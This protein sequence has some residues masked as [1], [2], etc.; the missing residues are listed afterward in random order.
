MV[1]AAHS[2]F[3]PYSPEVVRPWL[4]HAWTG[5]SSDLFPV[6]FLPTRR[7]NPDGSNNLVQGVT[8]LGHGALPFVFE[9]ADPRAWTVRTPFD[10]R[11]GFTLA[12][13]EGGCRITHTIELEPPFYMTALWYAFIARGHDWAIL[14]IF[15]RIEAA[16]RTGTIPTQTTRPPP[17]QAVIARFLMERIVP[18][19]V[20]EAFWNWLV[21]QLPGRSLVRAPPLQR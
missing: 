13:E 6:D 20:N 15:D 19:V 9:R 21:R 14:S 1:R 4:D 17:R 16:L 3:L 12:T 2:R 10:G 11:H 7:L 8:I 18:S 5:T